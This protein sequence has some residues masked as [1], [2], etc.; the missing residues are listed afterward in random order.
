MIPEEKELEE[1]FLMELLVGEDSV[2]E[3]ERPPDP[4][5]QSY[6]S[7]DNHTHNDSIQVS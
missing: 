2:K 1:D 7:R 3:D 5:R 6:R 4:G